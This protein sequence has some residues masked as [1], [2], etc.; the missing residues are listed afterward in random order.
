[1][2]GSKNKYIFDLLFN[3]STQ[4]GTK[5]GGIGAGGGGTSAAATELN[6]VLSSLV[7]TLKDFQR[8][9]ETASSGASHTGG[10][11][12]PTVN[13][14]EAGKAAKSAV[15]ATTEAL[16]SVA[17][18]AQKAAE[19]EAKV[20]SKE[21]GAALGDVAD[22][23][24][25]LRENI[26]K[27]LRASEATVVSSAV[28]QYRTAARAMS[29]QVS[30]LNRSSVTAGD[31]GLNKV[32]DKVRSSLQGV[33][34][35]VK[36]HLD[37][38]VNMLKERGAG[39]IV[40]PAIVESS[41]LNLRRT[42]SSKNIGSGSEAKRASAV[43]ESFGREV[44]RKIQDNL[45][46]EL[47][48][49]AST[50]DL[51]VGAGQET[52][53]RQLSSKILES[54]QTLISFM[55]A[56][57]RAG[58]TGVINPAV[59]S[60]GGRGVAPLV[61]PE[62]SFLFRKPSNLEAG[63]SSTQQEALVLLRSMKEVPDVTERVRQ[64]FALLYKDA[65]GNLIKLRQNFGVV[66]EA[67]KT[68]PQFQ[69]LDR[70]EAALAAKT[71]DQYAKALETISISGGDKIRIPRFIT[72]L[73]GSTGKA[74]L[75]GINALRDKI[76]AAAKISG[77]ARQEKVLEVEDTAGGLQ[78]YLVSLT[79]AGNT[80]D[81]VR[82]QV[83]QLNKELSAKEGL[84]LAF[85][86]VAMWGSAAGIV[87]GGVAMLRSAVKT[88]KD[89][90]FGVAS[91]GK[92]MVEA[93][94]DFAAF[95]ENVIKFA[96][97]MAK[98]Y[99]AS[100]A[101]VIG[102][103]QIFAQQGF[104]MIDVQ[105]L[106]E[107]AVLAANVTVLNQKD[108]AEGLTS[109]LHQFG[110]EA[111]NAIQIVDAW[112]EVANRN[113]VTE[114]TLT[115][116]LKKAGS[117]AASV[118]VNFDELN[119]M[120]T[121]IGTATRQ[122]GKEIGTSLRF[123]FQRTV[124]PE[125][126][127]ELAKVGVI[128]KDL[129][130]N[131]R[132]FMP[133]LIELADRW[134]TLTRSQRLSV[135]TALG[136]ARQYNSVL[137]LLNNFG[138]VLKASEE[139]SN[140][141]GSAMRENARIMETAEKV[142]AKLRASADNLAVSFGN[143]LLPV[144][145]GVA[146][147]GEVFLNVINAIPDALKGVLAGIAVASIGFTRF[148]SSID[149]ALTSS[150]AAG[151]GSIAGVFSSMAKGL[152]GG[153]KNQAFLEN[154]SK[155]GKLDKMSQSMKEIPDYSAAAGKHLAGMGGI[156]KDLNGN[157][158]YNVESM[159][160]LQ[161]A[162]RGAHLEMSTLAANGAVG[163][164]ALNSPINKV[165]VGLGK[166]GKLVFVY[167]FTGLGNLAGLLPVVGK[168]LRDLFSTMVAG[169]IAT[170]GF[171]SSLVLFAGVA[172]AIGVGIAALVKWGKESGSAGR[173]AEEAVSSELAKREEVLRTINKQLSMYKQLEV[174][175]KKAERGAQK[176][177]DER[178]KEAVNT[179]VYKSSSF[180]RL[181]LEKAKQ[182]HAL[183]MAMVS[184]GL[185]EGFDK[186]GNV[187]TKASYAF[188]DFTSSAIKA[189]AQLVAFSRLKIAEGYSKD[190]IKA[191]DKLTGSMDDMVAVKGFLSPQ[192]EGLGMLVAGMDLWA[193]SVDKVISKELELKTALSQVE[194]QIS[195]IPKQA[196]VEAFGVFGFNESVSKALD[197]AAGRLSPAY[198]K[199][200]GKTLG[201]GDILNKMFL[202][203]RGVSGA[204]YTGEE[205]A[206]KLKQRNIL[207]KPIDAFLK[208]VSEA[209]RKM[210]GG[211]LLIFEEGSSFGFDQAVIRVNQGGEAVV[212]AIDSKGRDIKVSL[213]EALASARNES[214]KV[215]DLSQLRQQASESLL[216]VKRQIA[217]AGAGLFSFPG[218]IDFGVKFNFELGDTD[219]L[220]K[221]G[222][223][224]TSM[225]LEV[226]KSQ[227]KYNSAVREYQKT[228]KQQ[229]VAGVEGV[230]STQ[231]KQQL[232]I[233]AVT[234]STITNI[235]R[236]ASEVEKLGSSLDKAVFKLEEAR[237]G[238]RVEAEFATVF[239][240]T[241]GLA[242]KLTITL[243]KTFGQL[244]PAERV[245]QL[246]PEF[247]IG[248]R[249]MD[250]LV[251]TLK[252]QILST[253]MFSGRDIPRM[254]KDFTD[255]DRDVLSSEI[256][257]LGG[258]EKTA[259]QNTLLLSIRNTNKEGFDALLNALGVQTKEVKQQEKKNPVD[260]LVDAFS[261]NLASVLVSKGVGPVS[262][263]DIAERAMAVSRR[264]A[265]VG[266]QPMVS[267]PEVFKGI[268]DV[269]RSAFEKG[270]APEELYGKVLSFWEKLYK[271]AQE[272]EKLV[273]GAGGMASPVSRQGIAQ[274]RASSENLE[275]IRSFID[276]LK[277]LGS[278]KFK[279]IYERV[280]AQRSVGA[281]GVGAIDISKAAQTL[282]IQGEK[283]GFKETE[284]LVGA[285]DELLVAKLKEAQISKE[286]SQQIALF[287]TRLTSYSDS[288]IQGFENI[289]LKV[290]EILSA[291]MLN[292]PIAGAAKG[293]FAPKIQLGK[294]VDELSP[295]E[296]LVKK[297]PEVRGVVIAEL[298]RQ[299]ALKVFSQQQ[300]KYL[301]AEVELQ[302]ELNSVQDPQ[303]RKVLVTLQ[304]RFNN[305]HI[306][307]ASAVGAANDNMAPFIESLTEM[308]RLEQ[309][310]KN[311]EDIV[312]GLKKIKDLRFDE[313]SLD[314]A[315]GKHPLSP[316]P[317]VFGQPAG[318]NKYERDLYS[319][320][321]KGKG[322]H[323]L[324]EFSKLAIQKKQVEFARK[325][326]LIQ[327]TQGKEN[328]KLA[329]E[330]DAAK[331]A[332]GILWDAQY[333][334]V[335]GLN[336]LISMLKSE[337]SSAGEVIS[338]MGGKKEFR[339]VPGLFGAREEIAKV[340]EAVKEREFAVQRKVVMQPLE[341]LTATGNKLLEEIKGLLDTKGG[342]DEKKA[343]QI[344][345]GALKGTGGIVA[346]GVKNL[347][348]LGDNLSKV[349]S[350]GVDNFRTMFDAIDALSQGNLKSF[351][352]AIDTVTKSLAG[353]VAAIPAPQNV[354]AGRPDFSASV[355]KQ[356]SGGKISGPAG[357]DRVPAMLTSGEYV[358][359]K[360]S[361]DKFG[362]SFMDSLK[363]GKLPGFNRGG[364]VRK[365]AQAGFVSKLTDDEK[366]YIYDFYKADAQA[367]EIIEGSLSKPVGTKE[368]N[369]FANLGKVSKDR[370]ELLG[371][372]AGGG[373]GFMRGPNG[374]VIA[375]GDIGRIRRNVFSPAEKI[376]KQ[377]TRDWITSKQLI[378]QY[379]SLKSKEELQELAYSVKNAGSLLGPEK[380]F[381]ESL[382]QGL[383]PGLVFLGQ[384]QGQF[385]E[386]NKIIQGSLEK[387]ASTT[388]S[389]L[390]KKEL[391]AKKLVGATLGNIKG[392]DPREVLDKERS[393][394]LESLKNLGGTIGGFIG[395]QF[396][397]DDA[398]IK[399][400]TK[401]ED[402]W[403][404]F[405]KGV[406]RGSMGLVSDVLSGDIL[407]K[408]VK[409]AIDFSKV[410]AKIGWEQVT[411]SPIETA[412]KGEKSTA[413]KLWEGIWGAPLGQ[414][415]EMLGG[416]L[417]SLLLPGAGVKVAGK[418]GNL[419][420]GLKSR[421]KVTG[422]KADI[423]EAQW[424]DIVRAFKEEGLFVDPLLKSG[425]I[426]GGGSRVGPNVGGLSKVM[427]DRGQ[428]Y[429][430]VG[431]GKL[432]AP[433]LAPVKGRMSRYMGEARKI[434][435][436]VGVP[437][438]ESKG[439]LIGYVETL[440]SKGVSKDEITNMLASTQRMSRG[441]GRDVSM[442]P[443]GPH[444]DPRT[445]ELTNVVGRLRGE[446]GALPLNLPGVQALPGGATRSFNA[447]DVSN[448]QLT[449]QAFTRRLRYER[450]RG[451]PREELLK[452]ENE[453]LELRLTL[454][455]DLADIKNYWKVSERY[456]EVSRRGASRGDLWEAE[457]VA[458]LAHRRAFNELYLDLELLKPTREGVPGPSPY[459]ESLGR[460][461]TIRAFVSGGAVSGSGGP[462][463]DRVPALLSNGEYVIPA[464]A[465]KRYGSAFFDSLAKPKKLASGG[466]VSGGMSLGFEPRV[467]EGLTTAI[468]IATDEI[469]IN[470]RGVQQRSLDLIGNRGV[471][472]RPVSEVAGG[473]ASGG[474]DIVSVLKEV[475][476]SASPS[477][478]GATPEQ[479]GWQ[480]TG[481]SSGY[482]VN[483]AG[484]G[485]VSEDQMKSLVGPK[486]AVNVTG[487]GGTSVSEV[488]RLMGGGKWKPAGEGSMGMSE[489]DF[490]KYMEREHL[491]ADVE[492]AADEA[493][494]KLPGFKQPGQEAV[495]GGA[496]D[497]DA[498]AERIYTA[499]VDGFKGG[500][501][502]L[503]Q[504][505]LVSLQKAVAAGVVEG[506]SSIKEA[507]VEALPSLQASAG[508]SVGPAL[509]GKLDELEGGML[510]VTDGLVQLKTDMTTTINERFSD[511]ETQLTS[512][513]DRTYKPEIVSIK[514]EL[515]RIE[516]F[517]KQ[518]SAMAHASL[519]RSTD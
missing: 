47:D 330:V 237:I 87:Y 337:L 63:L 518:V 514:G 486:G 282:R 338:T 68:S 61:T 66:V 430:Q 52:K 195:R 57:A 370:E 489:Q 333:K 134:D 126:V 44:I 249:S 166:F 77:G 122:P 212:E 394:T 58:G 15:D 67:M 399:E 497:I 120:I 276:N 387:P 351:G 464:G 426:T 461:R 262:V 5:G 250:R 108:A 300:Q 119:G 97:K 152:A 508:G 42:L 413:L 292:A 92:V 184:P 132:G 80:A 162:T 340:Q 425:T 363:N 438:G 273:R 193:E 388:I 153:P 220:Q 517:V 231:G 30:E 59:M 101:E 217:G 279:G 27:H 313:T 64:A 170:L 154:V 234:I 373:G 361:V 420:G 454:I 316:T 121:A 350:G 291:G 244:S 358:I 432:M 320:E 447:L 22:S 245:V 377:P 456:S 400:M 103:M 156:V 201:G 163:L 440:L 268:K 114:G 53:A 41:I 100:L 500:E 140:S 150:L 271:E 251:T 21:A 46:T 469:M 453:L 39:G 148:A 85:R 360:A 73:A 416:L 113:A 471:L 303:G 473:S 194:T 384:M 502:R 509:Q 89:V 482:M 69:L 165:L 210:R 75:Q 136:G 366:D 238:D 149:M 306:S 248:M 439:N 269:L 510:I 310:A 229:G 124:R 169:R 32:M 24:K 357:I 481:K 344:E 458:D 208:E 164:A 397:P 446:Q 241:A 254:F 442:S 355:E 371:E 247:A 240:S 475:L 2:A 123:I 468:K 407:E 26:G 161:L 179:G 278:E 349:L 287:A 318:L 211:E 428:L 431:M 317:G 82:V 252:A 433:D 352:T 19:Q 190:A 218:K 311:L 133:I 7:K 334:G 515:Q 329:Q 167:L 74:A 386:G 9:L 99:G 417:P 323:T 391:E 223:E 158:I 396:D 172:A 175:S 98:S 492:L 187:I 412:I 88:M 485:A 182:K 12:G 181:E 275:V 214:I 459:A 36:L 513:V 307:T 13:T 14:G 31:M 205:T 274:A 332:M 406:G 404:D 129:Q 199:T 106:T 206:S 402:T 495:S 209:R 365:Y 189:Q 127:S 191:F 450:S 380:D 104:E 90:E 84:T 304:E 259:T 312:K 72:E 516:G 174:Q 91:L 93:D 490:R 297:F 102:A 383:D 408:T 54:S 301:Q 198:S 135:A 319:I 48:S 215:F 216:R 261:V 28:S 200:Y 505:S 128:T 519:S 17:E 178:I 484:M 378:D 86:R 151:G 448:T 359:P 395:K 65:G 457:E 203:S 115:D 478:T 280:L 257:R 286:A 470:L 362:V 139:S 480:A 109:A 389:E 347:S 183:P 228:L 290:G 465:V 335:E 236:L 339:G 94:K 281:G 295:M 62:A 186:F 379:D 419:K 185:I 345:E 284:R 302:R 131:F 130:G 138:L 253:R 20:A 381:V 256:E 506:S 144:M 224:A 265:G 3:I 264:G 382:R 328:Q 112:N 243:P 160:K 444:F 29:S 230:I 107:A 6:A 390:K 272:R 491:Q 343:Q 325:E 35:E 308:S 294:S 322:P 498:L 293:V 33:D 18:E 493:T 38:L 409:G 367:R 479:R 410:A 157:I 353:I 415:G 142:F 23:F 364:F 435:G 176:T 401:G 421:K 331:R 71:L 233:Q 289:P 309:V 270:V 427:V 504:D 483:V 512:N 499:I 4:G 83:R 225:L 451:A 1:M 155:M 385:G 141:Q 414:K 354:P 298:E 411:T 375:M 392:F 171:A 242:D 326:A 405:G 173:V 40:A 37:N 342:E 117:A 43:V 207:E 267:E 369:I 226:F 50:F 429:G 204:G 111:S 222:K 422:K 55:E 296:S 192:T 462:M 467:L 11:A 315:F 118:G 283:A 436:D 196:G 437:R 78:K 143:T 321:Q 145:K 445:G 299:E 466:V 246:S 60:K 137:A 424:L 496:M 418:A 16:K 346:E 51:A 70:R 327:Y 116:A 258:D 235:V 460:A 341:D 219:R 472:Q 348:M 96:M 443:A 336:P 501:I 441:Y 105:R 393:K 25:T 239:G 494:S 232:D 34:V 76:A 487:L 455:D 197:L 277:E 434:V 188:D 255:K 403:K 452:L 213:F 177:E 372:S 398:M 95:S 221:V 110:I 266:G 324:E 10:G 376:S 8:G 476:L 288:L 45:V 285:T 463:S 356:A 147:G 202:Q 507:I 56:V 125:T 374:E 180:E 227:T 81:K 474:A 305:L 368:T 423:T 511:M 159:S 79:K 449:E 49:L 503:D 146:T 314:I 260:K 477:M 168:G 488:D 263:G